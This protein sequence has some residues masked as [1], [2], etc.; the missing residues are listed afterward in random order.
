MAT[1]G[2]TVA[3]PRESFNASYADLLHPALF[4]LAGSRIKPVWILCC[5]GLTFQIAESIAL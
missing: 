4:L 1:T 2:N 5:G 3:A